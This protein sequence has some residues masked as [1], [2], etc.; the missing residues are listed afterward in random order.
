MR[1]N[2]FARIMLL[3]LAVLSVSS[4]SFAQIR[5][6]VAFGPPA[7]PVYEQPICPGEGYIWTPGYW[8]WDDDNGDYYWV[9]GTW[10]LAP[11]VGYLWTPPWWGWEGGRYFFHAGYWGPH[12]GFYGGI[13][14]GFGY[15]GDGFVGGR[16]DH[17]HFFYNRSVTNINVVNI[18][19][20]Y[21]ETV[22]NNNVTINR[23][24]YNGGPGGIER[25]E[26]RDE[27]RWGHER[28][29]EAL[30]LQRQHWEQARG[31]RELRASVNQGRPSIA[32][33]GRPG[34]FR[35]AVAAREAGA[36]YHPPERGGNEARGGNMPREGGFRPV[37]PDDLPKFDRPA[38]PNTGDANRDRKYQQQQDKMFA[39]QEQQRQQLQARQ[40]QEHQRMERQQASQ[41]QRQAMEQRHQQQ[42]QQMQEKHTQ[43]QQHFEQRWQ[44]HKK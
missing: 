12:V 19:N 28:H 20:V 40:E 44:P 6:S 29:L 39:R 27:E 34:E 16:W 9:P 24:S 10:V 30:P 41:E 15:F 25:R 36:P 42:T 1:V 21:N 31:N 32:A 37:H 43:Q 18:H 8:A 33:T 14:Y 11:E 7:I 17:D 35:E 22:I 2:L 3:A 5:I 26:T 38:P 23:V 13:W 4:T